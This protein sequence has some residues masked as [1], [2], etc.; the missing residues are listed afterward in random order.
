MNTYNEK[1]DASAD[2]GKKLNKH[3]LRKLFWYQM[4]LESGNSATKQE[5]P[6]F[7]QAM[8]PVIEKLYD[9]PEDKKEAYRRHNELFLT[10]GR[11]A[12]FCIGIA[13]AMEERYAV[14]RDIDPDSINAVKVALMGPL[15][16]I[17]DSLIH[18]T[19]RPIFAGLACSMVIASNYTSAFGPIMFLIIMSAI[20]FGVR[21]FGTFMGYERGLQFVSNLQSG[22]L[23]DRLTSLAAIAAY[24]VCGGFIS[25]LVYASI[26]L[27]FATGETTIKIQEVLDGLMP[28]LIPLLFTLFV[29]WLLAKRKVSVIPLLVA[30]LIFG[31]IGVYAGFLA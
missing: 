31:I 7:A 24:V 20:S 13:A 25:S 19:A 12:S 10:E 15:A 8:I 9:D 21:Y 16:G 18:G 28:S 3:D 2:S 6:G 23:I 17:G 29:Y 26:P 30:T 27:E 1:S 11:V 22:G 14:H 5:G 4:S